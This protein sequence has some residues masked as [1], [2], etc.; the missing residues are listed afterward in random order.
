MIFYDNE[1]RICD[2]ET[3][4]EGQ[5]TDINDSEEHESTCLIISLCSR[6]R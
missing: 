5:V 4:D 3:E 6:K 1:P 2:E